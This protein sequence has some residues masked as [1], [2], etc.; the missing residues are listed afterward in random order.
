MSQANME[1]RNFGR[2]GVKVSRLILG[3]VNF[4]TRTDEAESFDMID[5]AIH[6]GI[7]FIDTSNMYGR[8]VSETTIGKG[9]ATQRSS[10]AHSV[11]HE[12]ALSHR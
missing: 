9:S 7:N 11:S 8:G 1:Y 2:T 6:Q 12:G 5:H 4:G 10:R 3:S